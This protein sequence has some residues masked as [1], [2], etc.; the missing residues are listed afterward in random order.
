MPAQ[1]RENGVAGILEVEVGIR[2]LGHDVPE[3]G[4]RGGDRARH[5]VGIRGKKEQGHRVGD[6]LRPVEA[7]LG[8]D[9]RN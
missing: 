5:G 8:R 7:Q 9:A 3:L 2:S 6:P 4:Q 1:L